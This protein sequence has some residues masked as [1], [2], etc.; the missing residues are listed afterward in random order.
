VCPVWPSR[1]RCRSGSVCSPRRSPR[2]WCRRHRAARTCALHPR[3]TPW[4]RSPARVH[5]E[6][7]G[8]ECAEHQVP[9]RHRHGGGTTGQRPLG[10]TSS[11]FVI[12]KRPISQPPGVLSALDGSVVAPAVLRYQLLR[13]HG[14]SSSAV[15]LMQNR[16]PVGRGPSLKTWPRWDPQRR[17][18]TSVRM[19]RM[20]KSRCSST[21]SATAG[22]KKL[23][24]PVPSRTLRPT[25]TTQHGTRAAVD[26]VIVV[27]V[28]GAGEGAL[29]A[30][31]AQHPV[32]LGREVVTPLPLVLGDLVGHLATPLSRSPGTT[33]ARTLKFPFARAAC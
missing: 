24:H 14:S 17:Q 11:F 33:P 7:R 5:R 12:E 27:V 20:P 15:E 13:A 8:E 2:Q 25:R 29:G 10:R 9:G 1:P 32:L 21:A 30:A 18:R 28:E 31:L 19:P 6:R 16:L 23:G 22:S 4:R 26:A 3:S